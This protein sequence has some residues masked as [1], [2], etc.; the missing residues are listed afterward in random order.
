MANKTMTKAELEAALSQALNT[1]DQLKALVDA[2]VA[3]AEGQA[4]PATSSIPSVSVNDSVTVVYMSESLGYCKGNNFEY[5]FHCVGEEVTMSRFAFDEFAGKYHS[6]F[7]DG[8]LAVSHKSA[9]IASAKGF[10]TDDEYVVTPE[11]IARLGTMSDI[12]LRKFWNS[13]TTKNEKECIVYAY[14]REFIN[15]TPGYR[16]IAKVSVLNGLT[17]GAFS[18]ELVEVSGGDQMIQA[19]DLML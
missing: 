15:N 3:T 10:K 7:K 6:W 13:T 8:I 17:N 14:K 12:E 19:R 16:D 9:D 4:S 1:I 2:K 18:R 5:H 11:K